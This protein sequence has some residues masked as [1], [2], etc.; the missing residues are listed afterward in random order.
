MKKEKVTIIGT[1]NMELILAP[2]KKI[3]SWGKQV[4]VEKFDLAGAGSAARVA[5]PLARLG[6]KSFILSNIGDDPYGKIILENLK[7]Y[8]LSR[9]GVEIIKGE[10]C[11]WAGY[12]KPLRVTYT[13]PPAVGPILSHPGSP[14]LSHLRSPLNHLLEELPWCY[15]ILSDPILNTGLKGGKYHG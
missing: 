15:M 12:T 2:L 5:F 1:L 10:R 13:E 6:I 4:L 11:H 3:P 9:E 7:D 14:I 8:D